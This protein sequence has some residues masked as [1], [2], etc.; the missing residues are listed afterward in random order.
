[1]NLIIDQGNTGTKYAVVNDRGDITLKKTT[2][3]LDVE[4]VREFISGNPGGH[5]LISSVKKEYTE[6]KALLGK[7]AG[8]VVFFDDNC[9]LPLTN[10]YATPKTLGKDRLAGVCG[11]M[12]FFPGENCLVIDAGTCIT[13]DFIDAEKNYHGGS[14]SPGLNM[15]FKAMHEYTGKL[16]L[17]SAEWPGDFTGNSTLTSMQTGVAFGM[18]GEINGFVNLYKNRWGTIKVLMCGGDTEFLAKRCESEIFAAPDLVISGLNEILK[19][20]LPHVA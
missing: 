5:L 17:V 1:M 14:I 16:P 13:Y 2:A 3:E 11:A 19:Y 10:L 4:T 9:R 15:R 18:V 20:N 12:A 7:A 8:A 6:I